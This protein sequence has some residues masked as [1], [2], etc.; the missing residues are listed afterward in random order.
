MGIKIFGNYL[1]KMFFA[2]LT[3]AFIVTCSGCADLDSTKVVLTTGF[4]GNELFRI[5]DMSCPLSEFMVYYINYK[6]E[7]E[8][9]FGTD[10]WQ[11]EDE[12]AS[13]EEKV[14]ENCL[15]TIAQVKAMNLLAQEKGIELTEQEISQAQSAADEYYDS[16][17]DEEKSAM[18]N[19]T[20]DEIFTLYKEYALADK[21]Y[22]YIIKD[23]N[24][25][26]SDDEARTITVKQ[27]VF[28]TYTLDSN[29]QKVPVSDEEKET[30]RKK[31]EDVARQLKEGADFDALEE[32]YNEADEGTV[33][34]GKGDVDQVVEDAAFNLDTGEVSGVIEAND[35]FVILQCISTFNREETEANKVRI[36]EE[37]K[38]EVFGEQY[39]AFTAS[40]SKVLNTD[41]WNKIETPTS[42][43]ISTTSF[44][45]VYK[46]YFE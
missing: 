17:T 34:F 39:D 29:G 5:E 22:E 19:I 35:Y 28:K 4:T 6:D 23:I 38:R 46:K 32:L 20:K 15:S 8:N 30:I 25:E 27:I 44:F 16:L 14:K 10:I 18:K 33:S 37:R 24:P 40:L 36:V 45:D 13:F 2:A 21:L 43:N 1:K 11:V 3:G 41:L 31:A 26:I 9:N 7:Y 12:G 42:E